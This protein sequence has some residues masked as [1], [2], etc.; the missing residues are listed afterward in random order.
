M[1]IYRI[2][3]RSV[4]GEIKAKELFGN[5]Q[6]LLYQENEQPCFRAFRPVTELVNDFETVPINI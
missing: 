2:I 6:S 4:S 5:T 1:M 3:I